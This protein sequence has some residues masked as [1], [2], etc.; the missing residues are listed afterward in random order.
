MEKRR[1]SIQEVALADALK[2]SSS[3]ELGELFDRTQEKDTAHHF[4]PTIPAFLVSVE[5]KDTPQYGV[6]HKGVFA[7]ENIPHNTK[8]WV[9]T[10]RI[11]GIPGDELR[12]YIH[13]TFGNDR[14]A[15]QI[16]LRQGFVLPHAD[17]FYTN[18]TDAGRYFKHSS[19]P[20][21]GPDGTLRDIK[22]GEELTMN[23]CFHNDPMWYREICKEYGTETEAEVAKKYS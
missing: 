7:L 13:K 10:D 11:K 15:I 23:Y 6:G 20:N 4:F 2:A 12:D 14:E 1:S 22:K 5:V 17:I 19:N 16:F 9:W 18:P 3:A 8:F 21:C